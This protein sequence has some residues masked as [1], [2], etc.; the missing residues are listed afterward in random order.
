MGEGESLAFS[1]A[2]IESIH[3]D[4]LLPIL[5][6]WLIMDARMRHV[7]PSFL[8]LSLHAISLSRS[9]P[10]GGWDKMGPREEDG[11][12]MNEE[13]DEEKVEGFPS[14]DDVLI[15]EVP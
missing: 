2:N 1:A 7:L 5:L 12:I 4:S 6:P 11:E 3:W 10:P 14:D 13:R 8:S 15:K 9:Y